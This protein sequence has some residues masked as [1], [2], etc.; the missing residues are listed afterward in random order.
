MTADDP[1]LKYQGRILKDDFSQAIKDFL[2]KTIPIF[3]AFDQAGSPVILYIAAWQGNEK[4]IW[5]E[6]AGQRF[7]RL[8][9]CEHSALAETL[10]ERVVDRRIYRPQGVEPVIQEEVI[11]SVEL[12]RSRDKIREDTEK[13]GT[14]EAVYKLEFPTGKTVWLKD[15]ATVLP[16]PEDQTSLSLGCLTIVT[17]EMEAE[18]EKQRLTTEKNRL[19]KQLQ[20]IQQLEAIGNLAEG[21]AHDLTQRIV[22]IQKNITQLLDRLSKKKNDGTTPFQHYQSLKN[23]EK[24][25]AEVN[26]LS[27]RLLTFAGKGAYNYYET[28]LNELVNYTVKEFLETR[29]DVNIETAF[30]ENLWR[31]NVDRVM[32]GKALQN[33]YKDAC[34]RIP[35]ERGLLVQ[36]ANVLLDDNFVQPFDRKAGAYVKI[37]VQIQEAASA[38][39][40]KQRAFEPFFTDKES[41]DV[42]LGMA[43][44]FG[45]VKKHD[46]LIT[47]DG[48][49][50]STCFNIFLPAEASDV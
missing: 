12:V 15:Q 3:H 23:I 37:S 49:I 46:G 29:P 21:I 26:N 1:K 24:H 42:G 11:S 45:I 31:A 8:M 47:L 43:A 9:G 39:R 13:T 19:E 34:R 6:F 41:S 40:D 20:Q 5:Y 14:S 32:L 33:L 48:D 2:K 35:K 10:R 22:G 25:L 4:N 44:V 7:L 38:E 50:E 16:F 30:Q 18:E 28:D 36:T 27:S 17:K